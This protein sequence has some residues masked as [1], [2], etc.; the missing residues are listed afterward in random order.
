MESRAVLRR[1][2]EFGA[3]NTKIGSL[4]VKKF[5]EISVGVQFMDERPEN[6]KTEEEL[7]E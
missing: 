3:S 5:A 6:Q 2:A 7:L 1:S 4:D